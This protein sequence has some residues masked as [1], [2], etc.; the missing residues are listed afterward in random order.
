MND[1]LGISAIALHEPAWV[2]ANDWFA[3]TMPRKFVHHTGIETRAVSAEDEVTMAVRAVKNL[4]RQAV[5]DLADCRGV[6]FASPSFIPLRI[7]R[8]HLPGEQV[9]GERLKRAARRLVRRLGMP[10]CPAIGINWF[11]S[12]YSRAMAIAIR[13]LVPA[14]DLQPDQFVLLV[15]SSRISRITDYACPQTGALFG[16]MAT[17]TLLAPADSQR[18]PAHFEVLYAQAHKQPADGVF[19]DFQMRQ[20]VLSPTPD[21]GRAHE[22]QR[23]VFT[24][25]GMG[26]ADAAPRAM[27]SATAAALL[28]AGIAGEEVRHVI[29]HQAGAGIVRLTAMKLEQLGI[30]GEVANG[31][32]AHVGNVSSCSIPYVLKMMWNRLSGTIVCPTAAVGNPGEK[33]VSQGC[34]LLRA[35]PLHERLGQAAA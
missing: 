6:V 29:P 20:N 9:R 22:A 28:A 14:L 11:C 1:H 27:S 19:F 31:L 34:I 7:A 33:E 24:L 18:Y 16:D 10:D 12:G 2:L 4:Q 32:T 26:I 8:Q 15:T 5:C 17:A 35:T 30:G 3:G 13:R 25:D 23:L 21:G